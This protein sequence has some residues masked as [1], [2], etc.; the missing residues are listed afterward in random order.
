MIT[1]VAGG[2]EF[3][4]IDGG[5]P[6]TTAVMVPDGVALD[7]SGNL[8]IADADSNNTVIWQVNLST[9]L[10]YNLSLIHI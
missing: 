5:V 4:S 10:I 2:V 8:Y 3:G 9:G 1:T 7:G 6:A